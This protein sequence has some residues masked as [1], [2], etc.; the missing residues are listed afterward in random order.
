MFHHNVAKLLQLC[1]KFRTDIQTAVDFL[2]TRVKKPDE[3][4]LTKLCRVMWYLRNTSH[5]LLTLEAYGTHIINRWVDASHA[6]HDDMKSH[7]GGVI[8]LGKGDIYGS[9]TRQPIN[10]QSSTEIELV[11]V[12]NMLPQIPWKR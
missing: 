2:T 10:T 1:K 7:P 4:D 6:V 3:D 8:T 9:S 12:N 5:I 11:D